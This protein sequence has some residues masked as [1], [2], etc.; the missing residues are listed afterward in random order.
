MPFVVLFVEKKYNKL[1]LY[2]YSLLTAINFTQ[3]NLIYYTINY[4][5]FDCSYTVNII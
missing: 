5:T 3:Q 1:I 4:N 2:T